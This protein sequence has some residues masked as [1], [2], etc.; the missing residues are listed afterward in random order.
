MADFR[1][2]S[3]RLVMNES[4]Y[5]P[6]NSKLRDCKGTSTLRLPSLNRLPQF[7][8]TIFPA[9]VF[10]IKTTGFKMPGTAADAITADH[11]TQSGAV[12]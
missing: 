5:L 10:C 8:G 4:I 12:K 2:V 6:L 3:V 1:R 11:M 9:R 7:H